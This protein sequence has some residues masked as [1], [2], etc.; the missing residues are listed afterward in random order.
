MLTALSAIKPLV[1]TR[2]QTVVDL[3]HNSF[4]TCLTHRS[5]NRALKA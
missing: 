2:A 5:G 3:V 4:E 1:P